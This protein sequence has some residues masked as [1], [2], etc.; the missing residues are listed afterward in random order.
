MNG[1][2]ILIIEDNFLNMKLMRTL[3]EVNRFE[4]LKANDAESGLQLAQQHRP[5]LILMDL[6]LPGM[7]GLEAASVLKQDK[8]LNLIPIIAV[9]S[10]AMDGDCEKALAAGCDGYL[11]KPI[12]TRTFISSI[13]Q[14][15]I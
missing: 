12:D 15:L 1:K 11:T 7:D 9:T 13:Q 6:H 14:Y 4:I 3:L 2:K 10:F 5:D 8:S